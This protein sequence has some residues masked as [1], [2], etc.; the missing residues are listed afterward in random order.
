MDTY[1]SCVSDKSSFLE[2]IDSYITDYSQHEVIATR[3]LT[4]FRSCTKNTMPK[5][6]RG[7]I[8]FHTLEIIFTKLMIKF[9]KAIYGFDLNAAQKAKKQILINL[10]NHLNLL[11]FDITETDIMFIQCANE[12]FKQ[13]AE[14]IKHSTWMRQ[15][16]KMLDN[17][18]D[19]I[20]AYQPYFD[21]FK[22]SGSCGGCQGCGR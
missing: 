13:D 14:V 21:K 3:V 9:F 6:T 17:E 18:L 7:V 2:N 1:A 22:C 20:A 8:K 15:L 10:N 19:W 5:Y 4:D 16:P 12:N 11:M